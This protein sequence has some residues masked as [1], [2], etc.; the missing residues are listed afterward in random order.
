MSQTHTVKPGEHLSLIA[1]RY[2]FADYRTI[3]DHPENQSLKRRRPDPN[4]IHPGDEVFIPDPEL[5]EVELAVDREHRIRLHLPKKVL[6][7]VMRDARGVLVK[8]T[9]YVLSVGGQRIEGQTDGN[10]AL[11]HDIPTDVSSATLQIGGHRFRMRVGDLNP[12]DDTDDGGITGLQ[13]RLAN[14]G[15]SVGRIDGKLGPRTRAAIRAFQRE[16]RLKITGRFDDA[17][18]SKLITRHGS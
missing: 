4:L 11:E 16:M 17:T 2:G 13:M 12:V 6:R 1:K 15:Y 8:D 9:P 10:G 14:L 18:K 5:K 3:Y 7:L